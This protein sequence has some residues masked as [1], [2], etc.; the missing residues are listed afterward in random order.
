MTTVLG[1]GQ[2]WLLSNGG[3]LGMMVVY[4]RKMTTPLVIDDIIINI[5]DLPKE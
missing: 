5:P 1:E 2:E 3:G 4:F